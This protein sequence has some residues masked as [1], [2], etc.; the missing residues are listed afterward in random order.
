M[1]FYLNEICSRLFKK[2]NL[3]KSLLTYIAMLT[4]LKLM[5]DD[6]LVETSKRRFVRSFYNLNI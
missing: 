3:L 4:I 5:T 1:G 6:D 2:E